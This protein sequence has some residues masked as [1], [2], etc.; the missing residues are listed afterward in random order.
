M[1]PCGQQNNVYFCLILVVYVSEINSALTFYVPSLRNV[2]EVSAP[3][4]I[5]LRVGGTRS[6]P[7]S[8]W[9]G[10]GGGGRG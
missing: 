3:G 10:G 8:Q 5:E 2:A 6:V 7:S 1:R 4:V 9:A